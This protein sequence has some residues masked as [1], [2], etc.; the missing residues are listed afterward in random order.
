MNNPPS[1]SDEPAAQPSEQA[2]DASFMGDTLVGQVLRDSVRRGVSAERIIE[3]YKQIG[4][5]A[6]AE[7]SAAAPKVTT[8]A[9][10]PRKVG[11]WAKLFGR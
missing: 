10:P 1:E 4:P 8:A 11:L 3:E 2:N 7:I 5:Q 6:R 9:V